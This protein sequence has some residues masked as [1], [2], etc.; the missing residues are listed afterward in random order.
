MRYFALIFCCFFVLKNAVAQTPASERMVAHEKRNQLITNG[1]VTSLTPE[2]IGPSV[3]SCRVTDLDVNPA[4]PTEMYVAYASG[5][6]WHSTNNGTSFQPVFDHEASMTIGDIAVDWARRV[7]WV[8]TGESNSSRSSYAGTGMYRSTDGGKTWEH[9][10]LPESHHIGRVVLHPTNPDVLWVAVLGHLYSSNA[11]RG[12]YRSTDGGRTWSRTL[13]VDAQSGA[14]DLCL[15]PLNPDVVYA[16]T[17][18]RERRAWNF[19]GAGAGS[20]I[21][22]STDGGATFAR[23]SGPSS[24][25]VSGEKTGRIGLAAGLKNGKTV[26]Y[27]CVDNQHSK[28]QKKDNDGPQDE[29]TKAQFRSMSVADF[30]KLTDE[31]LANYLKNNDFPEEYTSERVKSM[32]A[33]GDIVPAALADYLEDANAQLFDTDYIG[34]EVY[35]SLDGGNTWT[36]THSEPIEGMNFTYGYY[37]SNIRVAPSDADQVYFLGYQIIASKNGGA[38]WENIN[39]DNVHA[40]HHALWVHPTR[41][42]HLVNGNDGGVNISWDNGRSW[43]LCNQPPVGQFYAI[44]TDQALPYNVYGGAQDNGVWVGPSDY[45]ASTE[46]H[47]TG[48][49]PYRSLLGGDGMQ[50]QV[51]PR[52]NITVYTGYQ[53]GNY[54]RINRL[55]GSMTAITPKHRLGERPLRWNWETPIQLS[56]HQPDVL[57]MGANRLYRSFNRGNDWEA[58][59]GD[60]TAGGRAGNVP[61]G[62][63]TTLSESP[64]R[65]GLIYTGS[66]DGLVHITRDGGDTWTNISAGLPEGQWVAQVQASNHSRNRVFVALNG[67][68]F[69]N[70][71]PMLAMSDDYGATWRDIGQGLPAEPINVVRED[72]ANPD[73][74]YVGTDHGVYVSLDRGLTYSALGGDFPAVPV[75]DLAIQR[76]AHDLLIGTHGRSMYRLPVAHLEELTPSVLA[77]AIHVFDLKNKRFARGWGKKQTWKAAADPE[78]PV[79]F[80]AAQAGTAK[81]RITTEK[82]LELQSGEVAAKRGL[83]R[84]VYP[85]DVRESA[86]KAYAA[87]LEGADK[88]KVELPKSDTGKIYLQK[89]KYNLSVELNGASQ[90]RVLVVE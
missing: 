87:S 36:R 14:I 24:G 73:L 15:D 41:P 16:A 86:A 19:S 2:S 26:L 5:G 75:H 18:Q 4:D 31:K 37:F 7:I 77:E 39:G 82:G 20:A 9:R 29:L 38:T 78:Y 1:L 45:Q 50:V 3:F 11:E 70:F 85:L 10:G 30:A 67:Y 83:N 60:L 62:T 72:P 25:F 35:R 49:Y 64:L 8:G 90:T 80:Y 43:M 61:Y 12:V 40:D 32:V 51:D 46:W 58:I 27:A 66:D 42:G 84:W 74:L 57:Y 54:F 68:R 13:F 71:A 69:D 48:H 44:A 22:R 6:L 47:Q 55:N 89:G 53:F 34:A 65:F 56:T 76:K 17:W 52:D 63:L 21:W 28:P 88:K 81:W 79:T 23:V 33:K 59:S